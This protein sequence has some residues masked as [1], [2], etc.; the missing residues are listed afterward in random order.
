MWKQYPCGVVRILS[1]YSTGGGG[2]TVGRLGEG[3]SGGRSGGLAGAA[4]AEPTL[5]GSRVGGSGTGG[6]FGMG[7][8]PGATSS[9]WDGAPP[10]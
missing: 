9:L 5:G 3:A 1:P 8:G 7:G 2:G 4:E 10:A 6:G